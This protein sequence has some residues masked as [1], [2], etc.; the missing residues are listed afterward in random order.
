VRTPASPHLISEIRLVAELAKASLPPNEKTPWDEWTSDYALIRKS[1]GETYPEIFFGYE[2]RMWEPGGFQRPLPA[3]HR[4][5]KTKTGKA[6]FVTPPALD[7]DPDMPGCGPD[8]LRMITLRSNDQ[9]NT[10]VYGYD[11]RFRGIKGT[12]DV[13]LMNTQDIA[14]LGLVSGGTVRVETVSKDNILRELGGLRVVAYNI[15]PGCVGAYYPEANVLLPVWH[16]AVGSKT[17]A[18]KSI[19]VRVY[20]E[21]RTSFLKKRSKKLLSVGARLAGSVSHR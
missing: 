18:A 21:E 15:P 17:P 5:W 3:R 8:T 4:E 14:R 6:N 16:Y 20:K 11:D 2:T 1:I 13:L 7:E 19:P 9:F 12:R 10:T